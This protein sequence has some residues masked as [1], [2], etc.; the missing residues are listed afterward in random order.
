MRSDTIGTVRGVCQDIAL[1]SVHGTIVQEQDEEPSV[2]VSLEQMRMRGVL[3]LS[4]HAV[5]VVRDQVDGRAVGETDEK[6]F[7]EVAEPL[8]YLT[9][10]ALMWDGRAVEAETLCTLLLDFLCGAQTKRVTGVCRSCLMGIFKAGRSSRFTRR[11]HFQLMTN[12]YRMERCKTRI[13]RGNFG[14]AE[15]DTRHV[16]NN[17]KSFQL[18]CTRRANRNT[19]RTSFAAG[20]IHHHFQRNKRV[21]EADLECMLHA[22]SLHHLGVILQE[23]GEFDGAETQ[24]RSSLCMNRRMH[25]EN[26]DHPDIATML[27][28]L[29][30]V[31]QKKGDISGAESYYLA[32]LCMRRRDPRGGCRSLGNCHL[33]A[34]AG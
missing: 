25:G 2:A 15:T 34:S 17:R 18:S 32:S 8:A 23:K 29:G 4:G 6:K 24:Y 28:Q 11:K 10:S 31:L 26:A 16:L 30:A 3:A 12:K 27:N 7:M 1:R 19:G 33:V 21:E 20:I 5:A 14:G 13:R 9:I 22:S